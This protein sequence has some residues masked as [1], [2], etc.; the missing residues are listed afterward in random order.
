ML[1]RKSRIE[2]LDILKG[3]LIIFVILSHSYSLD[4]YRYF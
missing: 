4:I 1:D 3:I 2:W